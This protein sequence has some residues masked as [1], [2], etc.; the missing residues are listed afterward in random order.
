MPRPIPEWKT[1]RNAAVRAWFESLSPEM[2][3]QV[4]E[5][6]AGG[7]ARANA[8]R[9]AREEKERRLVSLTLRGMSLDEVASAMGVDRAGLRK[10]CTRLG[11]EPGRK[12]WRRAPAAWVSIETRDAI[13][14][15]AREHGVNSAEI[16]ERIL[17]RTFEDDALKARS[18]LRRDFLRAIERAAA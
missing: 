12:L 9:A 13:D 2:Q 3:A 11:I 15:F 5:A 7:K 4:T 14:A 16:V 10:Y 1:S 18:L 8:L 17:T 6:Q